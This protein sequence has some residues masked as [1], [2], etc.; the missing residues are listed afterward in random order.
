MT[1]CLLDH[2]LNHIANN[3]TAVRGTI[4]TPLTPLTPFK[5]DRETDGVVAKSSFMGISTTQTRNPFWT[6][7]DVR[8]FDNLRY[9]YPPLV[10]GS[11]N[12]LAS[13]KAKRE[14]DN[15]KNANIYINTHYAWLQPVVGGVRDATGAVLDKS[16]LYPGGGAFA[17]PMSTVR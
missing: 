8:D 16:R 7:D 13:A 17:D 1:H 4:E 2:L 12:E 6:S 11:T 15:A 14:A 9:R 10:R 3:Y 5:I